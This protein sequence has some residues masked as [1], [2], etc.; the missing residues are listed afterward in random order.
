VRASYLEQAAAEPASWLI[1]DAGR[2]PHELFIALMARLREA[3][4]LA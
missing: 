4:W 1:L 2:S 3:G